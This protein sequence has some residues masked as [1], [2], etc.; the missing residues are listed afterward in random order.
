M[1][2]LKA[3]NYPS[4]LRV[5]CS[6]GE[7]RI[8]FNGTN[9]PGYCLSA[10]YTALFPPFV[11][12]EEVLW[13]FRKTT[14]ICTSL[15]LWVSWGS[16][17]THGRKSYK[18]NPN[19]HRMRFQ[20]GPTPIRQWSL[21][22]ECVHTGRGCK[23]HK[24]STKQVLQDREVGLRTKIKHPVSFENKEKNSVVTAYHVST[25]HRQQQRNTTL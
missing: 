16:K 22:N 24:F 10:N 14:G 7:Q 5:C 18:L 12:C 23:P 21:F 9:L 13:T 11:Y 4:R 17:A 6:T 1:R 3:L 20:S 15:I 19:L 25:L 2:G 8:W